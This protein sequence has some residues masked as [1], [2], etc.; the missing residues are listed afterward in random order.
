ML[1]GSL[2]HILI[3]MQRRRNNRINN[4]YYVGE[5]WRRHTPNRLGLE[6]LDLR[7]YLMSFSLSIANT[8]GYW[9]IDRIVSFFLF[10]TYPFNFINIVCAFYL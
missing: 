8:V 7:E 6:Y 1:F 2:K 5:S 4:S 3:T 9:I 10:L